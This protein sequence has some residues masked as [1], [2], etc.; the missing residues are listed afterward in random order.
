MTCSGFKVHRVMIYN[1]SPAYI[2]HDSLFFLRP[3]TNAK[4]YRTQFAMLRTLSSIYIWIK[5]SSTKSES[6][7]GAIS[8][9][10]PLSFPL[11]DDGPGYEIEDGEID[12]QC[13]SLFIVFVCAVGTKLQGMCRNFVF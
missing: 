13:Q 1:M 8:Y 6:K 11:N 5:N 4:K 7:D 9:P 10:E 3:F 12:V 2:V